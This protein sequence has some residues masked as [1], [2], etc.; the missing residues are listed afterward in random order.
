MAFIAFPVAREFIALPIV[1]IGWTAHS[2]DIDYSGPVRSLREIRSANVVMQKWDSSCGAAVLVTVMNFSFGDRQDEAEVANW[3]LENGDPELI[4]KQGGFSLLDMKKLAANRG[5]SAEGYENLDVADLARMPFAIVPIVEYGR[6]P[7]FIVVRSI[8][9]AGVVDI[10]DPAFG[11][12]KVS[13]QKF[14]DIWEGKVAFVLS[15]RN[16]R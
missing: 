6:R 14:M 2:A 4:K 7:H 1:C 11:N 3:M 5:Y 12:R 8:D 13:S 15:R 9:A 16:R 10:A